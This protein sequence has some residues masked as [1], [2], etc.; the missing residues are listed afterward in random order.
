M[1]LAASAPSFKRRY[2]RFGG[3]NGCFQVSGILNAFLFSHPQLGFLLKRS[4]LSFWYNVFVG[5]RAKYNLKRPNG[6]RLVEILLRCAKCRIPE[7]LPVQPEEWYTVAMPS[8]LSSGS[9]FPL[10]SERGK[11]LTVGNY[12]TRIR[13]P[14]DL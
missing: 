6:K 13:S 12:S 8:F 1:E 5:I 9:S 4:K 10:I 11:N 2:T 3:G 7:F 14:S